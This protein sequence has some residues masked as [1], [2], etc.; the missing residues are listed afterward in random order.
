MVG[1]RVQKPNAHRQRAGADSQSQ[2]PPGKQSATVML[3]VD[4]SV[5]LPFVRQIVGRID[6]RYRAD[7]HA[8]TAVDA[9]HWI[10]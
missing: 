1:Q 9:L 4:F 8:G 6:G 10:D 7:W 5:V 3:G 2:L